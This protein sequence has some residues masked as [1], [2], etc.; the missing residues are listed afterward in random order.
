VNLRL[1]TPSIP[2]TCTTQELPSYST[3]E[4]E[5]LVNM[6]SGY[7]LFSPHRRCR[8]RCRMLMWCLRKNK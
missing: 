3:Y 7:V 5:L 2:V 1:C 6:L 8:A 4:T